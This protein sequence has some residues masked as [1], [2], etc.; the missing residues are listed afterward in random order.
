MFCTSKHQD[1]IIVNIKPSPMSTWQFFH[2]HILTCGYTVEFIL[3]HNNGTIRVNSLML[4]SKTHHIQ[5]T[6]MKSFFALILF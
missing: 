6:D 5:F 2:L 4:T 3:A 1:T